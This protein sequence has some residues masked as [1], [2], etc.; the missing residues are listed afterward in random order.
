MVRLDQSGRAVQKNIEKSRHL[1]QVKLLALNAR[2]E[3]ARAGAGAGFVVAE[4]VSSWPT[5]ASG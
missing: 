1:D 4:E 3:A 5:A 2:I